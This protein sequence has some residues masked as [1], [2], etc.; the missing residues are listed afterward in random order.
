MVSPTHLPSLPRTLSLP[1]PSLPPFLL[2]SLPFPSLP[3]SLPPSLSLSLSLSLFL[4]L[5][6]Q[7]YNHVVIKTPRIDI[8]SPARF[9]L[10]LSSFP[11]FCSLSL[12]LSALFY[13]LTLSL[14]QSS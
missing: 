3:P 7:L 13:P 6:Q 10:P 1:F 11:F 12:S 14:H 4:S 8:F 2:L 9:L 5:F